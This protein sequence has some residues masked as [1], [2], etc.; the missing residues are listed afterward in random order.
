MAP[1]ARSIAAKAGPEGT[2][3]SDLRL[4]AVQRGIM[5]GTEPLHFLGSVMRR[6]GLVKTGELRRSQLVST[7]ARYQVV[8]R[9]PGNG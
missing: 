9:L 5:A 1:L 2:T 7:H 4:Y 8:W 6:A 3:V